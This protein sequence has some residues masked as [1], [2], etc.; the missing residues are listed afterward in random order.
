M[1]DWITMVPAQDNYPNPN[2]KG[3]ARDEARVLWGSLLV[4]Q[5][6]NQATAAAGPK[7]RKR[8]SGTRRDWIDFERVVWDPEYRARVRDFLNKTGRKPLPGRN[9]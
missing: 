7:P 6:L 1:N 9:H 3:P 4:D 8:P 5:A 2:A